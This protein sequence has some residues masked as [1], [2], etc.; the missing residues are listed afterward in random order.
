MDV[1]VTYAG[2]VYDR[3]RA[4]YDAEVRAEGIHLL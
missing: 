3:T 4:L 1:S 2:V